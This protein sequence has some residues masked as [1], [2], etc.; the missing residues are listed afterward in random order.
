VNLQDSDEFLARWEPIWRD[1]LRLLRNYPIHGDAQD[2]QQDLVSLAWERR[3]SFV[4]DQH[5][6]RWVM[7]RVRWRAL[8]R[9]TQQRRFLHPSLPGA[10]EALLER[11]TAPGQEGRVV[12]REVSLAI[13]KLPP[14]QRHVIRGLFEGKPEEQLA[15]E[16]DVDKGT[17]RSLRRFGR[18]RLHALLDMGDDSE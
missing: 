10:H 15:A 9:L 8:D 1:A 7:Q 11:E 16:L 17:I 5:L 3:T 4:D 6:R 14:K 12:L 18:G 13:E 2:L